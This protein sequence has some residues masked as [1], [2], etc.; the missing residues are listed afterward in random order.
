MLS[1]MQS[2]DKAS[3]HNTAAIITHQSHTTDRIATKFPSM[4]R[5]LFFVNAPIVLRKFSLKIS[6]VYRSTRHVFPTD[7]SP[8][9]TTFMSASNVSAAILLLC[10]SSADVVGAT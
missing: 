5:P 7:E 3:R 1:A 2:R 8:I 4:I 9:M 6:C 10:C